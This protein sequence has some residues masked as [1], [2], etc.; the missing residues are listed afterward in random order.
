MNDVILSIDGLSKSFGN[1]H[2]LKSVSLSLKRG[3][4]LGLMGE[5]G[6]GKST[7]M[8]CLFGSLKSDTGK[9]IYND[10]HVSFKGPKDA[11]EQGITMVHQE[12]NLCPNHSIMDNMF[13]GRYPGK[14]GV[15]D[16]RALYNKCEEIFSSLSLNFDPKTIM[17]TLSVS[18]CQLV[19][20]AK[21][22]SYEA[23]VIILDEP[24]SSL[25]DK[26]TKT[27]FKLINE[28]KNKGVSFIFISHKMEEIFTICDD[29][30]VLRDG[31]VTLN[32]PIKDTNLDEVVTAMI[33]RKLESRFPKINYDI[34]ETILEVKNLTTKYPPRLVDIN[35]TLH[36]GE[37][38][39]VYGLVGSGRTRLLSTLFGLR[40]VAHGDIIFNGKKV[41]FKNNRDAIENNFAFISE[42]R[43]ATGMFPNQSIKFNNNITYLDKFSHFGLLSNKEMNEASDKTIERM[44]I[45]CIDRN[46]IISTLSGGNQQKVIIGKWLQKNPDI[47]IMDEPTRG[48]DIIAKYQVY[49]LIIEL[50]KQGKAVIISSSE[51]PE[52]MGMT[53]NIL[54]MSNHKIAGILSTKEANEENIIKLCAKYL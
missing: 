34:G 46:E 5:N 7:L 12:L 48:I 31:L 21:A 32:K 20:I 25:S 15:V 53:H 19:E 16:S 1:V 29:I 40:C 45:K 33:G 54:V 24:T 4:I 28:L 22:M 3:T 26:E 13:L 51:M 27:L 37:I 6:A 17:N 39:G 49:E 10:R 9:I 35:F 8:N 50:T 14:W 2:V 38:L 47:L 42:E 30:V 23:K 44:K 11:L 36:K 41:Q 18:E 43:K 52:I